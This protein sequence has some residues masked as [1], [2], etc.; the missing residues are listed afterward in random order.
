LITFAA[1]NAGPTRISRLRKQAASEGFNRNKWFGN[2]EF[3]VAKDVG[4]ETVRYVTN[5]YNYYLAYQLAVEQTRRTQLAKG[6]LKK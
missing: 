1:Y 2:V 3:M 5:I 6:A 4:Q